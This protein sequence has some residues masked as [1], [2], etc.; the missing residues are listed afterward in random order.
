MLVEHLMHMVDGGGGSSYGDPV[1]GGNGAG[2]YA[3]IVAYPCI[4]GSC[5]FRVERNLLPSIW[6]FKCIWLFRQFNDTIYPVPGIEC[7]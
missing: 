6:K 1:T 2:W 3:V 7:C 4:A 5:I